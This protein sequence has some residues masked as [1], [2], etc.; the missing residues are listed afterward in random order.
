MWRE[1]SMGERYE[2]E[3]SEGLSQAAVKEV[4]AGSFELAAIYALLSIAA[5]IRE[6][7]ET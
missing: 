4:H 6:G 5:A 1:A 2:P 3:T 7:G